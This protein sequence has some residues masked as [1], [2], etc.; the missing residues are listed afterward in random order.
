MLHHLG[1]LRC[2]VHKLRYKVWTGGHPLGNFTWA[3]SVAVQIYAEWIPV[4]SVI[5][6]MSWVTRLYKISM[7]QTGSCF[8]QIS[9]QFLSVVN[10]RNYALCD[11]FW[12]WSQDLKSMPCSANLKSDGW[13]LLSCF[14]YC[15][16]TTSA[17][18]TRIRLRSQLVKNLFKLVGELLSFSWFP[19]AIAAIYWLLPRV[20]LAGGSLFLMRNFDRDGLNWRKKNGKT[21]GEA[22]ERIKVCYW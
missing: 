7:S 19:A 21:V 14:M 16:I 15:R 13:N 20:L 22:H 1:I 4:N 18:L 6:A 5:P 11:F 10:L 17:S 3:L 12:L 2:S 8:C 9:S